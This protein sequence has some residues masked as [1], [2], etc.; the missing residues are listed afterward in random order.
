MICGLPPAPASRRRLLSGLLGASAGG[1][2]ANRL[3]AVGNGPLEIQSVEPVVIRTPR[4]DKPPDWYLEMPAVGSGTGGTGLWN[5]L[6]HASPSRFR[7]VTQATLVKIVTKGGLV[8]WGECHAPAAPRV[9]ATVVRDLLAPI[10]VGQDARQVE[11]LWER[12]YSSQ[13]LRGY[14]TGFYTESIA[15]TDLALWDIL[16][17]YLGQ[18]LYRILGGKYRSSV[19]T[20]SGIRG[21][22]P[23]ALGEHARRQIESGY[24][25]VKMGLSK[26]PGTSS[27]ERVVSVAEAIGDRG[28]LLVDSLGAYK[29]HEA[30][31]VG[32]R[33][34]ELPNI[35]WWEDALLP[36]DI[37]GYS[38]LKA[39]LKTPLC[40]GETLSNRFQFRDLFRARAVDM[41]NPDI[42]RAGGI[43]ECRRIAILADLNGILFSPHISTG[44]ALYWAASVH[45]AAHLPN[46]VIME[47]G[48][49]LERPFGNGLLRE[50]LEALPGQAIVPE[51]PGIGAE[52]D[53]REFA[54]YQVV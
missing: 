11:P 36:E 47:G 10:L 34:D 51:R 23:Q 54:R 7:G 30:R 52:F 43:S 41:V 38:E 39:A 50:P 13:R 22:T 21:S 9:H 8:G 1:A 18:P 27:V 17:K 48:T 26:G 25:A 3:F 44:T 33:L 4:G 46:T 6:D 31:A 49:L 24:S 14:A 40:A 53:E 37:A 45:L 28:Q 2:L 35:G 20:Y 42:C 19:P 32:E 29:V 15:G 16:G 12:L 5:R